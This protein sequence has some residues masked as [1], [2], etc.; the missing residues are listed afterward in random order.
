MVGSK[1]E[2]DKLRD[3]DRFLDDF[4]EED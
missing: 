3:T 4:Y 2:N 1:S